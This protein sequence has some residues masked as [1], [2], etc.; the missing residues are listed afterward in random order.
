MKTY[1]IPSEN[2]AKLEL[3]ISALARKA[4]KLGLTEPTLAIVG[5]SMVKVIDRRG[6]T[7]NYRKVFDV[8]VTGEAPQVEG[9]TLIAIIE[10]LDGGSA[11]FR[12]VINL[13]PGHQ[14]RV[15]PGFYR[16]VEPKCQHCKLSRSR[17]LTYL[18]LKETGRLMQVGSSCLKDFTGHKSP[19]ALAKFYKHLESTLEEAAEED[20]SGGG[21]DN[22]MS[23]PGYLTRVAAI[24]EERGWVSRSAAENTNLGATADI[25]LD[26]E[27][28]IE[29]TDKHSEVAEA[30]IAWVRTD[31]TEK[32]S[33][34]DYEW[35]LSAIFGQDE[36]HF[37]MK[38]AGY[39]A[40]AINTFNKI[41]TEKVLA[42]IS[43]S[44]YQGEIGERLTD[45]SL[46]VVKRLE[47]EGYNYDDVL[48]ITIMGDEENNVYVWKTSA[49]KLNEGET[50]LIAGTVKAHNEYKGIKQTILTRCKIKTQEAK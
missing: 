5:S 42:K 21:P 33:L 32:E 36:T 2:L 14:H 41:E 12:N 35:N 26:P 17:D 8:T 23:L 29:P 40:S 31:L 27:Y 10:H 18:I 38:H 7:G 16:T 48:H 15:L 46:T 47:Y 30:A 28:E 49:K 3:R 44:E 50:Y 20:W 4:I 6:P 22:W 9:W 24:I 43:E 19:E 37:H 45:L 1:E 39:V 11:D 13:L 25:A 34:N